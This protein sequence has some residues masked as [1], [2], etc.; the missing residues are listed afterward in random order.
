[1]KIKKKIYS[2]KILPGISLVLVVAIVLGL[3]IPSSS[4]YAMQPE[5]P[6]FHQ[7]ESE[8]EPLLLGEH[9]TESDLEKEAEEE[10]ERGGLSEENRQESEEN[11]TSDETD[12]SDSDDMDTQQKE[13]DQTSE[14]TDME[15]ET[16]KSEQPEDTDSEEQTPEDAEPEEPGTGDGDQGQEDG[17]EGEDG[18]DSEELDFA[19]V[20][21]WYKYGTQP[22]T[23]VC[24][25]SNTVSGDI[26][27][28]Q[29]I[30][31]ELKYSFFV[32]GNRADEVRITEVSVKEGDTD[33]VEIS[34]NG[35]INVTLP[36]ASEGRDYTFQ[37][38]TIWKTKDASGKTKEQEVL[39]TYVVHCAYS[40]D[41]ELE[42]SWEKKHD[43]TGKLICAAN[44]QAA[45]TIESYELTENVFSYT[46]KL[47]GTLAKNAKFVSGEYQT[48]SGTSGVL[49]TDGG[50]FVM[51]T[52]GESDTETYYLTF[53]AEVTDTDG[54]VQTV[55]FHVTIVFAEQLDIELSFTWLEKGTTPRTMRC[56]P[57][58]KV[59]TDIKNNQLSAG[60]VKYEIALN[61]TD[62]ENARILNISYTSE[63][64]GGGNLKENGTLPLTL[65][66]GYTS[67][68]YTILVMILSGGKQLHYE[69]LLHYSVDVS[70]EMTYTVKEDGMSSKRT[71]LCENEKTK[72]AEAIYD[73]QLSEG[74]LSY[75]MKLKGDKGIAITSV[76]CYQSGS[77]STASLKASDTLNLLLKNGKT[78]ENAF[79]V[80]AEDK[81]G[82]AY[83]FRVN[84]P[85]KHRGQNN[86]KITT[87]MADG[88]VVTNETAT[89][90][91]VSAWSEDESGNVISYIPANGTDTKLVVELDGEVISYVSSSGPSSEY[92]LYPKNPDTGDTNVHTL[93]IYAEDS[94]GNYGELS[95]T[96]KGQRNQAGQ[97][98]GKATI[99]VDMTVL[100]L[101][102]VDSVS[103]EVLADEPI[104]YSIAKAVL[105]KD[106]G[107][108]FGAAANSM[109]WGGRYT[110]TLD[111]GFYLQSLTPG[112]SAKALS[113]SSWNKYGANEQQILEAIDAQFGK[114]TGLATLWR[115]IYRNGLNKSG[116][117][118]GSYG[119]FDFTSGSGWLFSLDGTY[120]PGLAMSE[121]SL[122]D[123]DVL[124]LRYTLAH[125]WDV[126]SGTKGYGNTVGYCVTALNGSFYINHQIETIENEDGT[127]NYACRCCGLVEGCAHQH[128]ISQNM[129]DGTHIGFCEDCQT[130]V[131]DPEIHSWESAEEVHMCT[132]CEATEAHIWEEVEGSNTATCTAPGKRMV[133]CTICDMTREEDSPPKG[134]TINNRWNHTKTE[135][136]NRCSTCNEIIEESKG[137]HQYEYNAKDD[138]W[139]CVVCDAGH[140]WDY[141]GNDH[142]TD[143]ST[144]CMKIVYFCSDCGFQLEKRGTFPEFH[145][146]VDG[147]CVHCA[148]KD[149]NYKPP[150]PK[151]EPE[152]EPEPKPEPEPEPESDTGTE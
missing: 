149:P 123:G 19:M 120:Y 102:V 25:P 42:L 142:L 128:M 33:F 130:A 143:Q 55:Y 135:H 138:D 44:S 65:P 24:G 39:F 48:S 151:P 112:V 26:N 46:P 124:T 132:V 152:P 82:T 129:G 71:I 108:P 101:G 146:Y 69:I 86:I 94:F 114:G 51:Q 75:Q 6:S 144:T 36:N 11:E 54:M 52:T 7:P 31:N 27:T 115:C 118:D 62:S 89:N 127:V 28:A 150:E 90:F 126:G 88:Q 116:G 8:I 87:N 110:G 125:G 10:A 147:N 34:E 73:D 137:T 15:E 47:V 64:S 100:G 81:N 111:T 59:S 106:T 2:Q 56:Q 5:P 74:K 98:K 78:G 113:G 37:I 107:E 117:S 63:A 41:L 61:G 30:H 38:K 53:E 134:H 133:S 141:C 119:E 58:G 12:N 17:M 96:L 121:Y 23:I 13:Q 4:L 122:E 43:K 72:T 99:Y 32:T 1:M 22:K 93:K 76:T 20:M 145:A 79:T 18:G 84:I 3:W 57:N 14:D 77:G 95:L 85:Y 9:D 29:L 136:Y 104:S 83:E 131:G 60:A 105:G 40:L 21:T 50:S 45:K 49:N 103:Y 67:N 109:G 92:I 68:D 148:G 97:K 35:E 91:H 66:K 140:E 80:K 16:S 70:L 139:Y